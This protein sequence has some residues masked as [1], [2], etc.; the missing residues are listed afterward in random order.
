MGIE[1]GMDYVDRRHVGPVVSQLWLHDEAGSHTISFTNEKN[2]HQ[3]PHGFWYVS[4]NS[5]VLV[6]FHCR[7]GTPKDVTLY[8]HSAVDANNFFHVGMELRSET[9]LVT[10]RVHTIRKLNLVTMLSIEDRPAEP[11][12][13][14]S[15]V[16]LDSDPID[17]F[18]TSASSSC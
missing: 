1:I 16:L 13:N 10:T 15:W 12:D 14:S 3:E 18:S 11:D 9:G 8:T 5:V 2:H 6:A 17:E 4:E 7:G